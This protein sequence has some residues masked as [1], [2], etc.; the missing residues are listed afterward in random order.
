MRFSYNFSMDLSFL[1]HTIGRS[2]TCF[3][4]QMDPTRIGPRARR[5]LPQTRTGRSAAYCSDDDSRLGESDADNCLEESTD[6]GRLTGKRAKTT[7]S[8]TTRCATIPPVPLPRIGS[9]TSTSHFPTSSSA[10]PGPSTTTGT[11]PSSTPLSADLPNIK[12]EVVN[13]NGVPPL[14]I[15]VHVGQINREFMVPESGIAQSPFLAHLI[16]REANEPPYIMN[17]KLKN[18]NPSD[19]EAVAQFLDQADFDPILEINTSS[20][21]AKVPI[22]PGTGRL[23]GIR[24]TTQD[25]EQLLRL[26]RVYTLALKLQVPKLPDLARQKIVAGFPRGWAFSPMLQMVR[27][28]FDDIPGC[29]DDAAA[30]TESRPE[31]RSG[32]VN[33]T[34]GAVNRGNDTLK[35]WLVQSLAHNMELFTTGNGGTGAVEFWRTLNRTTGLRLAVSRVWAERNELFKGERVTVEDDEGAGG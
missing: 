5:Q 12:P 11:A 10:T 9:V 35:T 18:V 24:T 1:L 27:Q 21:G 33:S 3:K 6:E 25:S 16:T 15:V 7:S 13:E 29:V 28:V 22:E 2:L 19:F 30:V 34:T 20:K 26:G 14:Y 8:Y 32:P 4:I 17:P 31:S 23:A